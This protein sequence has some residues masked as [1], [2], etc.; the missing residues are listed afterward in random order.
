MTILCFPKCTDKKFPSGD[1]EL[2]RD[3]REPLRNNNDI[4]YNGYRRALQLYGNEIAID[5]SDRGD[6]FRHWIQR[7][8]EI[9]AEY[10]QQARDEGYNIYSGT[11]DPWRGRY[12]RDGRRLEP[13]PFDTHTT[14]DQAQDE[15]SQPV[16]S[17]N[18][19]PD[20]SDE[21]L[22]EISE[23]VSNVFTSRPPPAA[24]SG[25]PE[26]PETLRGMT[27]SRVPLPQDFGKTCVGGME[28]AVVLVELLELAVEDP[29]REGLK[30]AI[31]ETL[32]YTG[33][34]KSMSAFL[35]VMYEKFPKEDTRFAAS[36]VGR[37]LRG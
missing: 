11:S 29:S 31:K 10:R 24:R 30:D 14:N 8:P 2:R 26:K 28:M 15:D 9:I 33:G 19:E 7:S 22:P 18:L 34:S 36:T 4:P 27:G 12:F 35:D 16:V 32:E 13:R 3:F 17:K 37:Q 6:R 1:R 21:E 23:L 5:A 25:E 20:L